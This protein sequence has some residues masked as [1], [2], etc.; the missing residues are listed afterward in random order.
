MASSRQQRPLL[1]VMAVLFAAVVLAG[2]AR[3]EPAERSV[4]SGVEADHEQPAYTVVGEKKARETVVATMLV[5]RPEPPA[6]QRSGGISGVEAAPE[7]T[8][9]HRPPAVV[10]KASETVAMMLAARPEPAE[11][12]RGSG[13]EAA[14]EDT[15]VQ[16]AVVEK[17]KETVEMLMARLPAGP[18]PKGPGH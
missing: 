5:A 17:A 9:V 7:D 6:D 11:R 16:P 18:S 4:G 12:S 14:P 10:E 8:V 13:V 1:A 3:P 15:V 2:A